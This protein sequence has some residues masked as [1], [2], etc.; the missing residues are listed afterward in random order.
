VAEGDQPNTKKIRLNTVLQDYKDYKYFSLYAVMV[1]NEARRNIT[2]I[3]ISK[4][5]TSHF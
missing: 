1:K 5:T 3:N 2:F 4:K